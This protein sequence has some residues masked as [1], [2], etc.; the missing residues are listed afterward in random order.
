[1][2]SLQIAG[3]VQRGLK[4]LYVRAPI[5]LRP[6]ACGA[7]VAFHLAIV[8][9]AP[10]EDWLDAPGQ[11]PQRKDGYHVAGRHAK[12]FP[13]VGSNGKGETPLSEHFKQQRADFPKLHL[14]EPPQG[15][16]I[17]P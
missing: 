10:V 7:L 5:H 4:R 12:G 8:L 14:V 9:W 1:M 6:T 17:F 13:V 15:E 11:K 3:V 2:V 16:K